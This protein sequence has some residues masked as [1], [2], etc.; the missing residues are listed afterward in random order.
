MRSP[1]GTCFQFALAYRCTHLG[2]QTRR[3][4]LRCQ[5]LLPCHSFE[6]AQ[7]RF[8]CRLG[9]SARVELAA[10][11]G[12]L[13]AKPLHLVHQGGSLYNQAWHGQNAG[14]IASAGVA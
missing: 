5:R 6:L 8:Q 10:G 12:Q 3:I 13:L 7:V 2:L 11:A 9:R 14:A 1:T 4:F